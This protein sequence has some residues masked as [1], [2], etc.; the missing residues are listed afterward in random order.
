L[1]A[2]LPVARVVRAERTA[3]CRAG[4]VLAAVYYERLDGWRAKRAF[5]PE[6]SVT[7]SALTAAVAFADSCRGVLGKSFG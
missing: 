6:R 3:V 2:P 7:M 5:L 1:H 4:S